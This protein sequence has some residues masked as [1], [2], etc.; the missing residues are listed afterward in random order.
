[1]KSVRQ[2]GI[3]LVSVMAAIAIITAILSAMSYKQHIDIGIQGYAIQKNKAILSVLSVENL[4]M[5]MILNQDEDDDSKQYDY[6]DESWATPVE[7]LE[8]DGSKVKFIIFDAQAQFNVNNLN[9][10]GNNRRHAIEILR[11][12]FASLN[13]GDNKIYSEVANWLRPDGDIKSKDRLYLADSDY[14]DKYRFSNA[15]MVSI[16]ELRLM[17][18]LRE[19]EG[20]EDILV[21]ANDYMSFLP[22]IDELVKINVNTA[23]D[24]MLQSVVKYFGSAEQFIT[25]SAGRPYANINSFCRL[26]KK[27][28]NV[29]SRFFDVKSSYFYVHSLIDIGDN[30]VYAKSLLMISKDDTKVM[31]RELKVI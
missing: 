31:L 9:I 18:S 19:R 29:C 28:R 23:N 13:L 10:R 5:A 27:N 16:N 7:D 12:I 2:Q 30:K 8:F 26:M 6:Y 21:Q 14:F 25:I 1:M 4:A 20:L 3:A 22:T 24:E 17:V 11:N 15:P